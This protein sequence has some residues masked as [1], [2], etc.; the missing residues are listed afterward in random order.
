MGIIIGLVGAFVGVMTFKNTREY[1]EAIQ[2]TKEAAKEAEK[3]A[4]K[5]RDWEIKAQKTFNEIDMAV[6]TKLNE[7]EKRGNQVIETKAKEAIDQINKKAEEERKKS[8]EEAKKQRKISELWNEGLRAKKEKRYE[9]S[10][11]CWQEMISIKSDM[12][13]AWNNWG[14]ALLDHARRKEGGE[15]DNLFAESYTK[16]QEAVKIKPDKH[17]AWCNWGNALLNQAKKNDGVEKQ[18]LLQEAKEKYLRAVK[19]KR[20]AEVYNLACIAA[21]EEN[22][23]DCKRWL[24]IGEEAGELAP[25]EHAMK[26]EDLKAYWD[27]DWFQA[28]KWKEGK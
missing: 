1:R 14:I 24:K 7:I 17:E 26:D 18:K 6:V 19:M 8:Q 10:Y 4:D 20:G 9:D 2:E 16:F 22:E 15:A 23:E 21:I 27:K 3:A 12:H 5:A 13:E 28:I 25:R 11:K